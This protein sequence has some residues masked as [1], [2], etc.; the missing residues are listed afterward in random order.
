[1]SV[2]LLYGLGCSLILSGVGGKLLSQKQIIPGPNLTILKSSIVGVSILWT[3]FLPHLIA[4]DDSYSRLEFRDNFDKWDKYIE[5]KFLISSVAT[6][7]AVSWMA[8]LSATQA[9][10]MSILGIGGGILGTRISLSVT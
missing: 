4:K 6:I 10:A 2:N 1:M 9:I 5:R 8:N 3:A 7:V